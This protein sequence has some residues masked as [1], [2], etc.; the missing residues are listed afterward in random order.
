MGVKYGQTVSIKGMGPEKDFSVSITSRKEVLPAYVATVKLPDALVTR[1]L[2][3]QE[4]TVLDLE[5]TG[6]TKG[7]KITCTQPNKLDIQDG[8]VRKVGSFYS[9]DQYPTLLQVENE[10]GKRLY[11]PVIPEELQKAE[12]RDAGV[13]YP[14]TMGAAVTELTRRLLGQY[15]P[16]AYYQDVYLDGGTYEATE[17]APNVTRNPNR[18]LPDLDL[19]GV[20]V[21]RGRVPQDLSLIHI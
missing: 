19:S 13:F 8:V 14:G 18:M 5:I 12:R 21:S 15:T 11:V 9:N 1:R 3:E 2:L 4:M 17:N 6:N 7:L 20:S 16:G 10:Y